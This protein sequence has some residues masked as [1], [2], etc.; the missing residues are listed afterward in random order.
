MTRIKKRLGLLDGR[1]EV[2]NLHV[3]KDFGEALNLPSTPRIEK[4]G[5]L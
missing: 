1:S 2:L 4:T 3:Q 5:L